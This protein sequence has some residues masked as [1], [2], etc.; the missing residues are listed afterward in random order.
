VT[1]HV[2]E[3]TIETIRSGYLDP[4]APPVVTIASGDI[5]SYPDTWTHWGNEATYGMTFAGRSSLFLPVS[6]AGARVWVGN[7]HALQGDGVVVKTAIETAA[8]DLQIRYDVRNQLELRAPLSETATHWIGIGFGGSLEDALVAFLRELIHWLHVASGI[9]EREAYTLCSMAATS[10]SPSTRVRPVLHIPRSRPRPCMEWFR[11]TCSRRSCK[12]RMG[13]WL[14]P[15]E[16]E[17]SE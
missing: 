4:T 5:V 6:K 17:T 11:K 7:V 16:P 3:S 2:F 14:R 12:D 8:E 1:T 13:A 9:S 10:G 15:P